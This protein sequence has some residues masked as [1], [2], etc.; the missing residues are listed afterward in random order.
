MTEPVSVM[1]SY[2]W[3]EAIAAELLHEELS[4]WGVH[5][6]HDHYTFPTGERIPS[7]IAAVE[8]CDRYDV[9]FTPSSVYE[10]RESPRPVIDEESCRSSTGPRC[11]RPNPRRLR[12]RRLRRGWRRPRTSARPRSR[13]NTGVD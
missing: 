11:G 5:V 4:F 3:D 2:S 9:Y 13:A 8:R 12:T 1:V 7:E 6:D 10:T